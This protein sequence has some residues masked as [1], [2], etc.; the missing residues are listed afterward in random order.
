MCFETWFK[1]F[2]ELRYP[3]PDLLS[4]L[5]TNQ[6]HYRALWNLHGITVAAQYT[7]V[8]CF[9]VVTDL[10]NRMHSFNP[11]DVSKS[12]QYCNPYVKNSEESCSQFPFSSSSAEAYRDGYGIMIF[13]HQLSD[14]L[15]HTKSI[16]KASYLAHISIPLLQVPMRYLPP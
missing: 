13:S 4:S 14:L 2:A 16:K 6:R 7:Y 9:L 15:P 3:D 12:T 10:I 11:S 5:Y 8:L 1:S